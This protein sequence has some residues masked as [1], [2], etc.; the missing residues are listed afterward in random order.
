MS[1]RHWGEKMAGNWKIKIKCH[2]PQIVKQ[3]VSQHTYPIVHTSF[4][5]KT[6]SGNEIKSKKSTPKPNYSNS[7]K[8]DIE[9]IERYVNR[10]NI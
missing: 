1:V 3:D 6:R 9:D 10:I 5:Q 8:T 2:H 7:F 4:T